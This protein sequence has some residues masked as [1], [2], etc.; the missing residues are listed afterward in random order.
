MFLAL[1]VGAY[2]TGYF[3]VFTHAFFK[4]LLFL[5]AGSVIHALG[6]E[7]DIRRMGGLRRHQPITYI[8]F[9]IGTLAISGIP[10]FAGF[11]SKDS[12]LAAAFERSPALWAVGVFAAFLTAFYMGRLFVLVFHGES[13]AAAG[14]HPHESPWTMTL[15]LVFLA[16]GSVVA[17]FLGLPAVF[18]LPNLIGDFLAPAA[19]LF[20]THL[21]SGL[22]WLLMGISVAVSLAGFGLAAWRYGPKAVV[23]GEDAEVKGLAR[24]SLEKFRVDELYDAIIVRPIFALAS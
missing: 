9:L 11:F 14:V 10:P 2:G 1:G 15:P 19:G 22:E 12:I 16:L 13:R 4:A 20:E 17:G 5:G 7:Q 6:G 3:H 8:T 24:W 21:S 18:G 23:P